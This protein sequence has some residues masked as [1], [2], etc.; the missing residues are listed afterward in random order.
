MKDMKDKGMPPKGLDLAKA[1][2]RKMKRKPLP[3]P[4]MEYDEPSE[5]PEI[6]VKVCVPAGK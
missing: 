2:D 6:T 4:P 3:P 1:A 5:A